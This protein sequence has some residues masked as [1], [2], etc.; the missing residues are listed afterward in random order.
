MPRQISGS[1]TSGAPIEKSI[2]LVRG[3]RVILDAELA[4]LYGTT[5]KRLNEAVSR[6]RKRF[7]EDFM[8]Q[9]TTEELEKLKSHF[10]TSSSPHGGRRT[11]PY[12]FTEH[13]A[14]MASNILRS[15]EAVRMSVF[16]VRAFVKLRE[17]VSANEKLASQLAK[18]EKRI[19]R[20]DGIIVEIVRTMQQLVDSPKDDRKQRRIGFISGE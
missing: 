13:G 4:A 16:V 3:Q 17:M 1:G 14:I 15:E 7:P 5:T 11:L 18:L 12:A 6:N 9:L 10:A 19:D 20:H 2:L 8:F